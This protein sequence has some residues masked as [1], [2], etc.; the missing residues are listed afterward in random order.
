MAALKRWLTEKMATEIGG[1]NFNAS[2]GPNVNALDGPNLNASDGPKFNALDGPNIF[3]NFCGR[4]RGGGLPPFNAAE[5]PAESRGPRRGGGRKHCEQHRTKIRTNIEKQLN[6]KCVS[7]PSIRP[8][9]TENPRHGNRLAGGL[10]PPRP[11]G[12][13]D[14]LITTL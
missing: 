4:R 2:D 11:L 10:P 8:G 14:Q 6:K 3:L 12:R 1:P 7:H 5:P 9:H 13:I